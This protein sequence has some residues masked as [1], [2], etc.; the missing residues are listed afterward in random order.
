M[1]TDFSWLRTRTPYWPLVPITLFFVRL[2][3]GADPEPFSPA[4]NIGKV[5]APAMFINGDHD[6]LVPLSDAKALYELCP[7]AKKELWAI[8]G[9]T[10]GKCAEVGGEV[11]KNK[12]S[13]FF[14]E[15]L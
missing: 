12:V 7:S 10:H 1:V 6:D 4:H 8:T 3:L 11:Y 14:T 9:S 5:K 13:K 15:N 2:K